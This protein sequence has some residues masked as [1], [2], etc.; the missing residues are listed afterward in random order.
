MN[1]RTL[2][3][4]ALTV[5]WTAASAHD[6][7]G[8]EPLIVDAKEIEGVTNEDGETIKILLRTEDTAGQYTVFS[9][10]FADQ[11]SVGLHKHDWHDEAFYVIRGSYSVVNGDENVRHTVTEDTIVFTPRGTVH[12]WTALEPDSKFLV[13]LHP[14]GMGSLL[15]GRGAIDRRT[16]QRRGVHGRI[17]AELRRNLLSVAPGPSG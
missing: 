5:Y 12:A 9:D 15:R 11:T 8:M 3:A 13:I 4:F 1:A 7:M 6:Y 16:A 17:P 14:R 10:T 2:L